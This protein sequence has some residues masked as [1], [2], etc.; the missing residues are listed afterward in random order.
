MERALRAEKV[1]LEE[2]FE[3]RTREL[4]ENLARASEQLAT[5]RGENEA[6]MNEARKTL[7]ELKNSFEKAAKEWT[8]ERDELNKRCKAVGGAPVKC[9]LSRRANKGGKQAFS[10]QKFSNSFIFTW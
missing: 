6:L 8:A 2:R 7:V 1:S 10:L 3:S 9:M 5:V 4:E